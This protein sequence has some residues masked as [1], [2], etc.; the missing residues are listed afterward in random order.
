M[1][2][3]MIVRYND[4]KV[5]G[6]ALTE[7]VLTSP[8]AGWREITSARH[9]AKDIG[10]QWKDKVLRKFR[11]RL[12]REISIVLAHTR[13]MGISLTSLKTTPEYICTQ[14]WV[15]Y[16]HDG[17]TFSVQLFDIHQ[18]GKHLV[19]HPDQIMATLEKFFPIKKSELSKIPTKM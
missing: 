19:I 1:S 3:H 14:H 16:K 4:G 2:K 6:V 5:R 11:L 8:E 10:P 13:A 9:Y 15:Q 17:K 12:T 18:P 7:K